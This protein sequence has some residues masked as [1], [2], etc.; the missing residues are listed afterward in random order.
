MIREDFMGEVS[1]EMEYKD[2][3]GDSDGGDILSR[4]NS[5]SKCRCLKYRLFLSIK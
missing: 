5:M 3:V 4:G 1:F 2:C